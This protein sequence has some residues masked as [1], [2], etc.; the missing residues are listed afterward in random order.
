MVGNFFGVP[1]FVDFTSDV[2]ER[3]LRSEVLSVEG[4]GSDLVIPQL[5]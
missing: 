5:V 1:L 2:E 4:A 3:L